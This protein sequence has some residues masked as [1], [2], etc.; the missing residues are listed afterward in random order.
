MFYPL[1]PPVLMISRYSL[2]V[3]PFKKENKKKWLL[4]KMR[5]SMNFFYNKEAIWSIIKT[6]GIK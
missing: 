3:K 6:N 5:I 4:A 1:S 2:R